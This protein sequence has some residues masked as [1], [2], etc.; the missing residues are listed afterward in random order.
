MIEI[1]LLLKGGWYLLIGVLIASGFL[2]I[3]SYKIEKDFFRVILGLILI[4]GGLNLLLN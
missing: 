4:L 1:E 3:Y 2:S